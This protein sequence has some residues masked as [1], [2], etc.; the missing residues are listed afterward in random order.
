MLMVYNI[1]IVFHMYFIINIY[2]KENKY[3]YNINYT[4]HNIYIIIKIDTKKDIQ[5]ISYIL[6]N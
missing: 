6:R 5:K 2:N 1:C 3:L 4:I